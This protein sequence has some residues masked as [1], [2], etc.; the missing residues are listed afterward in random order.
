M[1]K[2][3]VLV[4]AL[5]LAAFMLQ[6]TMA[7]QSL[8]PAIQWIPQDAVIV[9]ELSEPRALLEVFTNDKA[10]AAITALPLYQEQASKPKF[11]EF[12]NIINF[13]EITLDTDWRTGL[14][15]LTGGGITFAV[16]PEDTVLLII[17]AEDEQMLERLHEFFLNIARAEA[18]KKGQSNQ[19]ASTE[20]DG[21]TAWTFNG[22]EAHAIIGKRLVFANRSEGLKAVLKLRAEAKG[23]SL[24][25]NPTYQSA[26]RAAGPDVIARVFTNLKPLMQLPKVARLLEQQRNNPLAALSFAGIV[27]AVR[28]S[29]WLALG[30]HVEDSKLVF[31]A[32]VDGKTVAPTSPAAFALPNKPG[33]GVLPNL[34]VPR[35]IAALSLYRDLHQFYAAKDDLFPDRTS[36]LIFFENM[37]GIF[38]SGRD[39]T[40]E[41][42]AETKPEIRIVVAEQEYDPAIG[43]PQIKLPAFAAILRL[44]RP[45]QFNEVAEEAWQKAVGLINFTRGQQALPGLIIG[46]PIQGETQFTVAAF[47]TVEIEDK[48]KLDQR[49]NFRPALAMPGEYLI[50][51]STD[52]LARDLIDALSRETEHTVKPFAETHSLVEIDAAQLALILEANRETLVRGDMVKKGSTQEEA[53]TGIDMLITVV[54]F[55]DHVKLSIGT[56]EGLT[57]ARLEMKLNWE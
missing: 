42:L 53:E 37:M 24:V 36:G 27:E 29:N 5:T 22:E 48:T 25:S 8:P 43:T 6:T 41:V 21:V 12:L 56:H 28:D 1:S 47:S 33:E 11:K 39:L 19:V 55:V 13:I 44:C 49:F 54:K 9:L 20:Y 38:F 52:G 4:L 50:L 3:L 7:G 34:S 30:L 51:S 31:R 46:R 23:A 17:D 16:C 45:E 15:K 32:S 57:Q 10:T 40:N 14:A 35:R 2:K 26:K 18:E